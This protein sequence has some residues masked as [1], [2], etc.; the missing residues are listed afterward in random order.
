MNKQEFVNALASETGLAK[1]DVASV[2]DAMAEIVIEDV[3]DDEN[4]I[5]IPGLGTFKPKISAAR[6]GRNPLT[7]ES[8][9]IPEIHTIAFKPASSVRKD[10]KPQAKKKKK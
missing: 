3:R 9:E 1:K 8:L 2:I 4:Q 5:V 6:T 7:G 10:I